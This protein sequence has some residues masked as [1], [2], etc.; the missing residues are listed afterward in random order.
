MA[1]AATTVATVLLPAERSRVEAAGHGC[2]V[3]RHEPNIHEATLSARR[4]RVDAMFLSVHCCADAD[5]PRVAQFVR[6]FPHLPTVA[7]IS[8]PDA[9]VGDRVLR[10]GASGVRAVVDVSSP[11]GWQRLREV[12]REP[13]SP[14]VARVLAALDAEVP[15]APPDCRL[16]FEVLLRRA[17]DV[18][19]VGELALALQAL[20]SSLM[21][22]FYRAALPSPKIYL[23]HSRL[24]HAAFLFQSG[25]L[26]IS[27]VSHRLE[28]SSPQSFG[29]HLQTL[30]GITAGEF[31]TRYPFALA[32]ERFRSM[33]IAPFRD[34]LRAF[35]PLGTLPGGHGQ[36]AA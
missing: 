9:Q 4:R 34:K 7:L 16:F 22:R 12:L 21:S 32:V 19:T 8:R 24:L 33:H 20:P 28:Y 26:S 10:L 1:P 31:R 3:A 36:A 5:L 27:D 6:E 2:Y 14:V 30:L 29:R 17:P 35:H 18:K 13:G 15:D 25:G 23:S 11:T